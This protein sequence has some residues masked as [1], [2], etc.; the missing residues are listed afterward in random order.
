MSTLTVYRI[1][2]S[3]IAFWFSRLIVELLTRRAIEL[4]GDLGA[5]KQKGKNKEKKRKKGE[6]SKQEKTRSKY[7]EQKEALLRSPNLE[8]LEED[9]MGT[10]SK[11]RENFKRMVFKTII[12]QQWVPVLWFV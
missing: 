10:E 5:T 3:W 4:R 12:D 8:V 9:T 7:K 6:N 1:S 2:Y 11:A